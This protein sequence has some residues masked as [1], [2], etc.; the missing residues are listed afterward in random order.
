MSGREGARVCDEGE[1]AHEP[2]HEDEN[3][4]ISHSSSVAALGK[5]KHDIR[6]FRLG[7]NLRLADS[8]KLIG[9]PA[10]VAPS[11]IGTPGSAAKKPQF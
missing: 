11:P 6:G 10:L 1:H 9:V 4:R 8:R 5:W 7:E 3:K 2:E